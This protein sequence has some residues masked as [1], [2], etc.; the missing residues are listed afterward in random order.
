MME[1]RRER[2]LSCTGNL[3]QPVLLTRMQAMQRWRQMATLKAILLSF[4][5]TRPPTFLRL[6]KIL[7]TL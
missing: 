4:S 2:A 6:L 7:P 5:E 1:V 3:Q